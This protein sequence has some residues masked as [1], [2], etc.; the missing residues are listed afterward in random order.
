MSLRK[1]KVAII[2]AGEMANEY[3]KV[4]SNMRNVDIVG[5]YNRTF[6]KSIKLKKNLKLKE[7][8]KKNK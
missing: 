1:N 3:L 5:I 4:L 2:G 7:H 6:R 8:L